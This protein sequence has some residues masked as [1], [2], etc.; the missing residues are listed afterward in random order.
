MDK[1]Q[2]LK[3][4]RSEKIEAMRELLNTAENDS[5]RSLTDEETNKYD[6]LDKE[7]QNLNK[8]IERAER[9]TE[10]DKLVVE[11]N[12]DEEKIERNVE[13]N[14]NKRRGLDEIISE[15]LRDNQISDFKISTRA[16]TTTT[17]SGAIP[18]DVEGLSV[19][20][21]DSMKD[22]M[23]SLGFKYMSNLNGDV[24]LPYI[25]PLVAGK[26]AEGS[27]YTNSEVLGNVTLSTNRFSITE[28]FSKELLASGN[29]AVLAELID[30][31]ILSAE[32]KVESQVY[33]EVLANASGLTSVTGIT[34]NNIQEM[35][36]AID[37]D[38]VYLMPRSLFFDAK[39]VKLDDGSGRF[40]FNKGN[41]TYGST[42]EGTP[43]LYSNLFNGSQITLV[44]PNA[45]V[46]GDWGEY[47]IT[48]DIYS[49]AKNGQVIITVSKIADVAVRAASGTA[50][51][52]SNL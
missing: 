24:K 25:Q 8:E 20:G 4:T 14:E 43:A 9:Q 49:A 34:L 3:Q 37:A 23:K 1:I 13:I 30:E 52:K 15:N 29:E 47:D 28:T 27:A 35:E 41:N 12:K 19:V 17:A 45:V 50:A 10:L 44:A 5:K 6:G 18:V 16:Q 11:K 46:I 26:V 33:T 39:A 2:E 22:R 31:M 48:F 36:K 42:Y 7:V 38:S 32:R 51:V 21:K 40:L